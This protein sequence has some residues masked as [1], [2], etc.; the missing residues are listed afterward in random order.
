MARAAIG[1]LKWPVMVV[2]SKWHI[3]MGEW[4]I[5]YGNALSSVSTEAAQLA[6]KTEAKT[7]YLVSFLNPGCQNG[8]GGATRIKKEDRNSL[9]F[10]PE[11]HSPS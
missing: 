10:L 4:D 6:Q 11:H 9:K 5:G 3:A 2:L 8:R 1:R 7:L